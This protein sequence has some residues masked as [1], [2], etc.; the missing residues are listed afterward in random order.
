MNDV[1]DW[2]FSKYNNNTHTVTF[3]LAIQKIYHTDCDRM[4]SSSSGDDSKTRDA[5]LEVLDNDDYN[6]D[7]NKR[8]K[9]GGITHHKSFLSVEWLIA[10][11]RSELRVEGGAISYTA[12]SGRLSVVSGRKDSRP[13]YSL[14]Y[15]GV[16]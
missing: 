6:D 14:I 12:Y 3:N 16:G 4:C 2:N 7:D 8:N 5:M 13:A 10:I 1:K 11:T 9:R 15:F